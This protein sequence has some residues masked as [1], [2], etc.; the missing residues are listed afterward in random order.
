MAR[1][2]LPWIVLL[3]AATTK[4]TRNAEMAQMSTLPVFVVCLVFSG[5]L[6]PVDAFHDRIAAV[7]QFLPLTPVVDLTRLGLLGTTGDAPAV[8]LVE[9][10]G[11]AV[12]PAAILVAWIMV[13]IYLTRRWFH[14]EPRS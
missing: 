7:A 12:S 2:C 10:F 11:D 3:A 4:I 1:R 13:G 8:G 9:T 14:W 6:V 5:M